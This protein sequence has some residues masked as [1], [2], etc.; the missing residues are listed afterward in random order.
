MLRAPRHSYGGCRQLRCKLGLFLTGA[1]FVKGSQTNPN[2]PGPQDI[3]SLYSE[4]R[5]FLD[6]CFK[7][8]RR[9]C[10]KSS[11]KATCAFQPKLGWMLELEATNGAK[12]NSCY[13]KAAKKELQTRGQTEHF[14][15]YCFSDNT[16]RAF[17][18]GIRKGFIMLT[19][20]GSEHLRK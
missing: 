4:P 10:L 7:G 6:V 8:C 9:L 20:K 15:I 1:K 11:P 3:K 12:I 5:R 14:G 2:S 13:V 19:N 16:V 18:P 17:H